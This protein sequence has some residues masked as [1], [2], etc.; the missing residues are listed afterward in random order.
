MKKLVISIVSLC[1]AAIIA[2]SAF[3]VINEVNY[4]RGKDEGYLIGYSIGQTDK[5]N[6]EKQDSQVLAGRIVPYE[7]G[8]AKW[9]GFIMGF[10]KGYSDGY[11][12]NKAID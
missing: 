10:S 12:G 6:D 3:F 9:K 4:D 8:N 2:V 7:F 1:I 11:N 5:A